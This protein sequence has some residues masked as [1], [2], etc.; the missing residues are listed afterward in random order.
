MVRL[1]LLIGLSLI[2]LLS[3]YLIF[4]V[5]DN[6]IG[7]TPNYFIGYRTPTSMSSLNAWN[8]SQKEFKK[9]FFNGNFTLVI[10]GAGWLIYDIFTFFNQ[11]HLFFKFHYIF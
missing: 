11:R 6:E 1:I 9:I 7:D 10:I 8:Y 2:S 3:C 5:Q 4:V